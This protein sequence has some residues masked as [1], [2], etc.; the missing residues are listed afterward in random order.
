VMTE[1]STETTVRERSGA[2]AV[3]PPAQTSR[4]PLHELCDE[5]HSR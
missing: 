1:T 3:S 4:I 5:T 2:L